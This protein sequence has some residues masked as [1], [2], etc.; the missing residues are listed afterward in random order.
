MRPK[1][2]VNYF[3]L[4]PAVLVFFN[5]RFGGRTTPRNNWSMESRTATQQMPSFG[6]RIDDYTYE[7][8]NKFKR[9]IL[10]VAR[11]KISED[12]KT[13]EVTTRGV[14]IQGEKLSNFLVFEKQ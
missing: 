14:T 11:H 12:G 1:L 3:A 9:K 10:T 7:P 13:R 5:A 2:A 4:L 6:K 8:T